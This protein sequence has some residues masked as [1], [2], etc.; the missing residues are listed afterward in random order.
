MNVEEQKKIPVK[1]LHG[2]LVSED[3]WDRCNMS[4]T[5]EDVEAFVEEASANHP[6]FGLVVPD[7]NSKPD[8]LDAMAY[9]LLDDTMYNILHDLLMETYQEEK[10]VR[11]NTA[12]IRLEQHAETTLKYDST[13]ID[14]PL[15]I[16]AARA[17]IRTDV[18]WF[19]EEGYT[20]LDNPPKGNPEGKL[21]VHV[22][23]MAAVEDALC[24][25][26]HLPRH[27]YPNQS[28]GSRNP[29]PG[30]QYCQKH[31]F[32][33]NRPHDVYNQRFAADI[34]GPG[35]GNGKK[36]SGPAK[37]STPNGSQDSP[38]ASPPASETQE[39]AV[40]YPSVKCPAIGCTKSAL[41]QRM[42]A[43]LATYHTNSGRAAHREAR[44]RMQNTNGYG[45]SGS[46]NTTPAP[47]NG[48][49]GRSSPSKRDLDDFDSEE[50]PQ[51]PKKPK[52]VTKNLKAAPLSKNPSQIS[53]SNL[54]QVQTQSTDGE[55]SGSDYGSTKPKDP[56]K[57][58]ATATKPSKS[59]P[60]K[61]PVKNGD[62]TYTE[63]D[64]KKKAT[65]TP[66]ATSTSKKARPVTPPESKT[67]VRSEVNGHVKKPKDPKDQN[68]P[69]P[70]GESDSSQT[71]SSS[72]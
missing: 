56:K 3:R 11:C 6:A 69:G 17:G 15:N 44:E 63:K 7:D 31:I 24:P 23:I 59:K 34:K 32:L 68:G 29:E 30:T 35:K 20:T 1:Q 57:K 16:A 19:D 67:K 33:D 4:A 62:S 64:T 39:K 41:I 21:A 58:T 10:T 72:N 66:A 70:K 60:V 26:C 65:K 2:S 46:R 37:E 71:M 52:T 47:T 54:N 43:H 18:A 42:G 48:N 51:K 5:K 38:T 12:A 27:P 13:S 22:N 25:N 55:D 9:Q 8:A 49:K 40:L 28:S 61:D 53:N 45:S 36:K 50:S 14:E